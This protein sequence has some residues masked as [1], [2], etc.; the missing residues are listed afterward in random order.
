MTAQ[1]ARCGGHGAAAAG[2]PAG[3]SRPARERLAGWSAGPREA[4]NAAAYY[5]EL[6]AAFGLSIDAV[7]PNFGT[8][9]LLDVIA[10]S[11]ELASPVGEQ[12]RLLWPADYGL[13]RIAIGD[14]ALVYPHS[15]IWRTDNPHPALSTL[16]AYLGSVPPGHCDASAWAPSWARPG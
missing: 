16:R 4:V 2:W 6:A 13:R 7:G 10:D 14:P 11:A 5:D 9:S 15:L 3:A 1:A 8:Q 12:T